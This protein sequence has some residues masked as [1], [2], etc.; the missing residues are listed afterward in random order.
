[1]MRNVFA[2]AAGLALLA[3]CGGEGG[4]P[5]A[6]GTSEVRG[7]SATEIVI[8]N[9]NDLSGPAAVIGVAAVNGARMLF[10][11]V[12]AAGGVHGRQI[13]FV[14]EDSQYQV[15]KSI[16][17]TNKLVNR[18]GIFAM[19]LGM[20]TPMNNAIMPMLFEKN[21]PNLFPLTGARSMSE[22]FQRLQFVS[23]G[24]YYDQIQAAI[25]YFVDEAGAARPC[26]IYQD[27]D[28]GQEIL[29]GALDQVAA[30]GI[31]LAARSAH[32][33]TDTEF[34]ASILRLRNAG[35]D[36]VLMGT[37]H[38][39]TILV[40]EA[41]RKLAWDN[42]RWVGT[43]ASYVAAVAE[44]ESGASEGYSVFQDFRPIH[45]DD[46][47]IDPKVA[48]WWDRYIEKYRLKPDWGAFLGY[49]AAQ[50]LVQGLENA[51]PELTADSLVTGLEAIDG[52]RDLFGLKYSFGPNDHK[53]ATLANLSTVV[54]G[55]WTDMGV[56]IQYSQ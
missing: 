27:T 46:P 18:D 45:R 50:L 22:P 13:R 25:R 34:T 32:K 11:E 1:M 51:G 21:I 9:Q 52:F 44:M 37:I 19:I 24:T 47:A 41:A 2:M 42:V 28:F 10:E 39:D 14:V 55:R 4:D 49:A 17:A 54:D 30:L 3:A 31:E 43:T 15:P 7:V 20:G 26:V 38:K 16:Q 6:A 29:D 48:E 36:L 35:C 5:A 56:S 53:A 12:N 33:P 40:L 8:G 23:L